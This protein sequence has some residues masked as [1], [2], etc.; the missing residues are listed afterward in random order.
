MNAI[1]LHIELFSTLF[2][3]FTPLLFLL[4]STCVNEPPDHVASENKWQDIPELSGM[5][6]WDVKIYNDEIY[7]AGRD[8][9]GKG[10][11]YKSSDAIHW[12]VFA[13]SIGDSLEFGVG[14]ID[15]YNGHLIAC[16]S[17]QPLYLIINSIITRLTEPLGDIREMIVDKENNIL[18][19]TYLP[20]YFCKYITPDSTYDIYDSLFTPPD[21]GCSKQAGITGGISVSKFLINKSSNDILIGNFSLNYHFVS[22]FRNRSID[23]FPNNG[24]TSVDRFHG[25]H[26]L[27]FINDTLFAAGG[28]G[29]IKYL[30]QIEWKV[31]GDTLPKTPDSSMAIPTAIAYDGVKKEIYVASNYIGVTKWLK[32]SRWQK[33]N[34]GLVSNQGYY[35][36]IPNISY[37]KGILLLTYGTSKNYQSGSRGARYYS[38]K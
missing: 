7:V 33:L 9:S 37:F 29:T 25:C 36:F 13:P 17:G 1:T 8:F 32:N 26:D 4:F 38:L 35:D 19:G 28:K 5:D 18:I 15:F 14:A 23:C 6:I 11:I 24:L 2:K 12:D 22:A 20:G 34:N 31:Y 30:D 16:A 10:A 21:G 27:I 3:N